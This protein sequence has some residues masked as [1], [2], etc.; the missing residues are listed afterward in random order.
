MAS[1]VF[2]IDVASRDFVKN[3]KASPVTDSFE[4]TTKP[5][6][7]ASMMTGGGELLLRDFKNSMLLAPDAD[8]TTSKTNPFLGNPRLSKRYSRLLQYPISYSAQLI[9]YAAVL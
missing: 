9:E 7:V 2:S 5:S 6:I 4:I 8:I 3:S 1:T